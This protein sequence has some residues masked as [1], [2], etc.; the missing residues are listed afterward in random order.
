MSD[1]RAPLPVLVTAVGGGG[2]GEQILKALRLAA[3]GRYRVLA[4]DANP[5]C[6]QLRLADARFTLPLAGDPTYLERLLALCRE[7]GVR[8]LFHGCEPEDVGG[9]GTGEAPA[10]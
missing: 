3:P 2:H 9:A 7:N 5:R 1:A 10:S 8:A 4:A 6:P